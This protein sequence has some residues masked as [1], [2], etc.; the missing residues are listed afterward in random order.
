MDCQK[1]LFNLDSDI[2]YLNGAY[3]SPILKS[4][5]LAGIRGIQRKRTPS[6][7]KVGDF[8]ESVNRIR[9]RFSRLINADQANRIVVMPS[10]SYGFANVARNLPK[11]SKS[12]IVILHDQ[13]PSNYYVW[14]NVAKAH[15]MNVC[16]I[17]KVDEEDD[18]NELFLTSIDDDTAVVSMSIVHWGDGTLFDVK[19]IGEKARSVGALFAIDGTQSVGALPFDLEETP[20]NALICSSYKWLLGPYGLSLA[21]YDETFDQGSPIEESWLNRVKSHDFRYLTNYQESYRDGARRYEVGE[22][23][24]FI[25]LPMLEASLDQLL[26][27]TPKVIQEYCAQIVKP[28]LDPLRNAGYR[29]NEEAN[30]AFHLFGIRPPDQLKMA[31]VKSHLAAQKIIVSYRQDA[32][33]VSPN[34]YNDEKDLEKLKNALINLI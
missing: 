1:L 30:M 11:T 18:W 26:T 23:P 16:I 12:K 2:T 6:K 19:S 22:A 15:N 9:D 20:V 33:R 21:F 13:F 3:M 25:K 28:I 10:A 17:K 32:I 27:W 24:D 29:I 14:Q 4:S 7:L 34:V 8:F 31:E 5:E